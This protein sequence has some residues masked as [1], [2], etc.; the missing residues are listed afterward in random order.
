MFSVKKSNAF[1]FL[2]VLSILLG[3]IFLGF[4]VVVIP[5]GEA[6]PYVIIA[7]PQLVLVLGPVLVFLFTQ[8]GFW[9]NSLYKKNPGWVNILMS[10]LL[11][12]VSI[13]TVSLINAISMFFVE[14]KI[15]GT[16]ADLTGFPY[17][18]V[19]L[20]L[21]VFPGIFEE[22]S[23][24]F[25]LLNNYRYKSYKIACIMSGLFFG[26]LHLN[27]N[28]FLYA[29]VL[30]ILFCFLVQI[31]ESIYT[32][33]IMHITLNATTFTFAYLAAKQSPEAFAAEVAAGG[34]DWTQILA[35]AGVNV[36]TI[37]IAYLIISFLIKY[38]G[39]SS[40]LKQNPTVLELTLGKKIPELDANAPIAFIY[41]AKGNPA[42]ISVIPSESAD[43][44]E[45]TPQLTEETVQTYLAKSHSPFNW[46]FWASA[47]L[48]ALFVFLNEV[49][50]R[51]S[52]R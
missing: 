30:G 17:F 35:I 52:S 1:H 22:L 20:V 47:G 12:W 31:T 37:P 39:K 2:S 14:N 49:L 21:A 28:Q 5:F 3:S 45:Q 6:T 32:S 42:D 44:E 33:I 40:V 23:T 48:F 10:I 9:K 50:P 13:P 34:I 8:S 29:F 11:I 38:N 41:D 4:L 26:I 18:L 51:L 46:G 25:I 36:I 43:L 19:I 16:V 15:A 27:V 24:R 7:F